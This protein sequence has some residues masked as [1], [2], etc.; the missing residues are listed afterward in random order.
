MRTLSIDH[1]QPVAPLSLGAHA[2]RKADGPSR[3]TL[4]HTALATLREWRR[5]SVERDELGRLD[6]RL[7]RDIG[8]SPSVVDYKARHPFW[9]PL[10][11]WRDR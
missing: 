4:L 1:R 3:R 5:R 10:R 7:L 9:R 8:V 2:G 11:D 6:D